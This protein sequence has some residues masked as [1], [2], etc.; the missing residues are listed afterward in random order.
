MDQTIALEHK[1]A[2]VAVPITPS[3][4][5]VRGQQVVRNTVSIP[6]TIINGP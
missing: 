1:L 4:I 3:G 2:S 6:A 5:A